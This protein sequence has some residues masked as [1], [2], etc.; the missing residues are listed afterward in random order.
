MIS[1]EDFSLAHLTIHFKTV[2]KRNWNRSLRNGEYLMIEKWKVDLG[3]VIMIT[4]PLKVGKT[5]NVEPGNWYIEVEISNDDNYPIEILMRHE[6]ITD[7]PNE[8]FPTFSIFTEW[9]EVG[10]FDEENYMV[11]ESAVVITDSY[12]DYPA[13]EAMCREVIDESVANVLPNYKGVLLDV[14]PASDYL[15]YVDTLYENI[16]VL[17][18]NFE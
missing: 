16:K 5:L 7:I 10:I 2:T 18:V 4:E 6:S 9:G 8:L 3:Q 17:R 14:G 13:F 1:R 11:D 12:L 15:I